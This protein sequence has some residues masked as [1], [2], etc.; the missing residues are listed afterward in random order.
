MHPLAARALFDK[1]TRYLSSALLKRRRWVLHSIEFPMLD[2]S[3]TAPQ[4][5]TLRLRLQCDDWNDLPPAVSL[6]A[7]DGTLLSSLA[8]NPT[9][10]FNSSPHPATNRPFV[11]MRG[12]RE[13]HTH[14]SHLSD[15]WE[16]VKDSPNY[17]L[18]GILTQLW[19][20]WQKGSD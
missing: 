16:N 1:D 7:V 10:V 11:C 8:S 13:Y 5:T 17:T 12:A 15:L 2:C 18:G 20:A 6:H 19:H 14:S 3:F 9:G 4:R